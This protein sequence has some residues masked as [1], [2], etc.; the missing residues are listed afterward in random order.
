MT[1]LKCGRTD[2]RTVFVEHWT[3]KLIYFPRLTP[4]IYHISRA[5]NSD[6][7]NLLLFVIN[8]NDKNSNIVC[9]TKNIRNVKK[10]V[11]KTINLLLIVRTHLPCTV[12][13]RKTVEIAA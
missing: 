5:Q 10:P 13:K 11:D 7:T 3:P 2:G 1:Q 9:S 8:A 6:S 4:K 12:R